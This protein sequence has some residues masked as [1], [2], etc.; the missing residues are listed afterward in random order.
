[1]KCIV[2]NNLDPHGHEKS[3]SSETP[4]KTNLAL[5]NV[6]ISQMQESATKCRVCSLLLRVSEQFVQLKDQ[7]SPSF[8]HIQMSENEPAHLLLQ[9]KGPTEFWNYTYIQLG[10]ASSM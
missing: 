10:R 4:P 2:C 3:K 8:A 1:M 9:T 5:D 7:T 6:E